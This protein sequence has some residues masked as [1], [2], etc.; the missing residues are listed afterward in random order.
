MFTGD[1]SGDW[2]FAGLH[3]AGLANQAESRALDDGLELTG[4]FVTATCRCAPPANKPTPEEIARCAPFLDEE[5]ERLTDLKVV[6]ALGRIGWDAALRRC[7]RVAP[8]GMPR[9]RPAFAHGAETTLP[10][11]AGGAALRL[12]G[13][14]HPSQQNTQTG[15]LTRAM[16]DRVLGRA[17]RLARGEA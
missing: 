9:P 16:F 12:L 11:G 4:A 8:D 10:L 13:S 17:A 3:R 14:Y 6:V 1:R 5:F 7:L 2:L 15:R